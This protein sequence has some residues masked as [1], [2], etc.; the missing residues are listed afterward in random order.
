MER[1]CES[2][3]SS[4]RRALILRKLDAHGVPRDYCRLPLNRSRARLDRPAHRYGRNYLIMKKTSRFSAFFLCAYIAAPASAQTLSDVLP[5]KAM[6]CALKDPPEQAGI[7]A[8]PGGFVMVYPRNAALTDTFTGCKL[9]WIVD[10]SKAPRYATLYFE[11]GKLAIAAAH[12]T[13]GD[14][15]KLRAAC[16]FPEGKS[17]LPKSGQQTSDIGCAGLAEDSFYALRVPTWPRLCLTDS[18][19]VVCQEDPR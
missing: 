13:R 3:A 17:L 7:A 16:A 8:T 4:E 9:M 12:D 18:A 5:A 19:A 11:N 6:H 15:S 2:P 10:G 14:P 1:L